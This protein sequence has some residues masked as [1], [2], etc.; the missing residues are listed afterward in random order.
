[1]LASRK[2]SGVYKFT[3]GGEVTYTGSY[4]LE[5]LIKDAGVVVYENCT[6][7]AYLENL[8]QTIN[9]LYSFLGGK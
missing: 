9:I 3:S 7:Y 5:T 4:E 2:I 8:N 1:M 6:H